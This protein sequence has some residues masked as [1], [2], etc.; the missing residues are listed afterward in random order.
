LPTVGPLIVKSLPSILIF[1]PG[2]LLFTF[3]LFLKAY[4]EDH[5]K[6]RISACSLTFVYTFISL[7]FLIEKMKFDQG[8][9]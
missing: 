6:G 8:E 7:I 5:L 2:A 3:L 9:G 4:L 1:L